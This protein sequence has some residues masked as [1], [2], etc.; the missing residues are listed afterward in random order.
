M[1]STSRLSEALINAKRGLFANAR[2]L[3]E[4]YNNDEAVRRIMDQDEITLDFIRPENITTN[5][6]KY[7]PGRFNSS[8]AIC[9]V[10][11]V[12][13]GMDI[14]GMEVKE[15]CGVRLGYVPYNN[16]TIDEFYSLVCAARQQQIKQ[17]G[18]DS[19]LKQD[20]IHKGM[21]CNSRSYEGR[22]PNSSMS[23]TFPDG[24]RI[25]ERFATDTFHSAI[26]KI[27]IP[28]VISCKEKIHNIPLISRV[29]DQ[30]YGMYQRDLGQGLLLIATG[31]V[32]SMARILERISDKLHLGIVVEIID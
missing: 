19:I 10:K 23:V 13:E 9:I 20:I 31:S 7:L 25:S 18:N 14:S 27:G 32:K 12:K 5:I 21:E 8:G 3:I 17:E 4:S 1:R 22:K 16:F 24:S 2:L 6:K 11:E 28:N 15:L 29:R 26:L 30:Q